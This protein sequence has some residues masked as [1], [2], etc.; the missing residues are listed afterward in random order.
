M[1]YHV[2][3]HL[4]YYTHFSSNVNNERAK[5]RLFLSSHSMERGK[6]FDKSIRETPFSTIEYSMNCQKNCTP[7]LNHQLWSAVLFSFFPRCR[8]TRNDQRP[9]GIQKMQLH[10]KLVKADRKHLGGHH[11]D[12]HDKSPGKLFTLKELRSVTESPVTER[13][14]LSCIS[15]SIYFF[16]T[17][18]YY[19]SF[20][21]IHMLLFAFSQT[22]SHYPETKSRKYSRTS[23]SRQQVHSCHAQKD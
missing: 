17:I 19:L 1:T 2:S 12:H 22:V 21:C 6:K 15:I 7:R 5:Q 14:F 13:G 4:S 9:V 20:T 8:D 3:C 18:F 11:H 16:R 23:I 10:H